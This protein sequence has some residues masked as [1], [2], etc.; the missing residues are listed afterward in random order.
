[1]VSLN[2]HIFVK[3]FSVYVCMYMISA[4]DVYIKK[5]LPYYHCNTNLKH[6][7]VYLFLVLIII[8]IIKDNL[9]IIHSYATFSCVLYAL[10]ISA[11]EAFM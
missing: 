3:Y 2:V 7:I 8:Q 9:Y 11:T 6:N 1:M 5:K 4:H 10:C